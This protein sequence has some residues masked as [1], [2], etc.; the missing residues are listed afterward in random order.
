MSEPDSAAMVE[1][2][3]DIDEL[4]RHSGLRITEPRRVVA[5][6]VLG[7]PAAMASEAVIAEVQRRDPDVSQATVYRTLNTLEEAG[8]VEHVHLGHS[9]AHWMSASVADLHLVCDDCGQQVLV[10]AAAAR[11]F[12]R[13]IDKSHGFELNLRH[14]AL[15]GRCAQC[16]VIRRR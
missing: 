1:P 6:V 16:R 3:V 8:L 10:P 11:A 9:S 15:T 12:E 4:L 14:F 5:A 2:G 7:A 13:Q